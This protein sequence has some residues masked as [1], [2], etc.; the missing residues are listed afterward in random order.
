MP[1]ISYNAALTGEG[2]DDL[3]GNRVLYVA[4]HV[5]VEGP[6]VRIPSLIDSEVR[7][8]VGKI[9]FGNDITSGGILTGDAWQPAIWLNW[10][11]GQ[12]IADPQDLDGTFG[13]IVANR[14]HWAFSPGTQVTVYVLGDNV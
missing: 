6:D 7:A 10:L 2:S 12:V 14:I 5:D 8:G 4:W 13:R 1:F 11:Q 3:S 9:A